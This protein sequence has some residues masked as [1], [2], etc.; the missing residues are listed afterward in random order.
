M[1]EAQILNEKNIKT[2]EEAYSK[3]SQTSKMELFAEIVT[4][5][6]PLNILAKNLDL[7]CLIG[8]SICNGHTT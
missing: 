4:E 3:P 6:Q 1:N 5:F 7:L 2:S 8:R